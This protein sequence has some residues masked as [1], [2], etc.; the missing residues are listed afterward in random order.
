MKKIIRLTEN[1]LIRIVKRAI[2]EQPLIKGR[3]KNLDARLNADWKKLSSALSSMGFKFADE[4]EIDE[5]SPN[6]LNLIYKEFGMAQEY[7]FVKNGIEIEVHW[8][9][10]SIDAGVVDP[11]EVRIILKNVGTSKR[12]FDNLFNEAVKLAKY[13]PGIG[14]Q[15]EGG[16]VENYGNLANIG[17]KFQA[18]KVA[19]MMNKLIS[20]LNNNKRALG[21]LE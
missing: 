9:S 6:P 8:P 21:V 1:D 13:L 15:Q 10:N 11:T 18:D 17:V 19:N 4:Y 7:S 12:H 5:A 20:L 14:K 2:N 3:D 16:E